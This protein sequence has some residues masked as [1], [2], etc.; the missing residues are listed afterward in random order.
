MVRSNIRYPAPR[1][2]WAQL[3]AAP[4]TAPKDVAAVGDDVACKFSLRPIIDGRTDVRHAFQDC[5]ERFLSRRNSCGQNLIGLPLV[6]APFERVR[7]RRAMRF[8]MSL[9]S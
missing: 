7:S 8:E 1:E 5:V 4:R 6:A 3:I 9:H 2:D